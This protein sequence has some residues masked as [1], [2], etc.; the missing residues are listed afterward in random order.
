MLSLTRKIG[1]QIIIGHDVTIIVLEV[2]AGRV[3]LGIEAPPGSSVRR[4]EVIATTPDVALATAGPSQGLGS[5][6]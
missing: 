3:R 1:E 6:R 2:M 5:S 4:S